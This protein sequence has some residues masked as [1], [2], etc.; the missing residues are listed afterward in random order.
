M[1][2][3]DLPTEIQHS[4]FATLK[5]NSLLNCTSTNHHFYNMRT[6]AILRCS[7]LNTEPNLE[8]IL[9]GQPFDP[10]K[11]QRWPCYTAFAF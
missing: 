5:Y 8:N 6:A 7:L 11:G 1:M 2:F 9:T 3:S 10:L 4:I